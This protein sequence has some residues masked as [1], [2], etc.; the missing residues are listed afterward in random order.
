GPRLERPRAR[1]CP[2]L[3]P[4]PRRSR[5][6][7]GGPAAAA[8]RADAGAQRVAVG[9]IVRLGPEHADVT[10]RRADFRERAAR[11][12]PAPRKR[13]GFARPGGRP[14]LA[15]SRRGARLA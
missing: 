11:R 14:L 3:A 9:P 12:A 4:A 10:R 1:A 13:F 15:L 2:G 5:A 6:A 8:D 7:H